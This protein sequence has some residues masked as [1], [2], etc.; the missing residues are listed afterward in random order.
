MG[1]ISWIGIYVYM[2]EDLLHYMDDTFTYDMDPILQYYSPYDT[3]YPSKQCRLLTLWD[4]IRLPHEQCKQILGQSID[5]ICLFVHP[6]EMTFTM[7]LV[8]KDALI[9]AIC[10]FIDPTMS[11]HCPLIEW[12]CL[13]G[14]M[15]WGLN[16]FPLLKPGLQSSY[17][18]IRG[19]SNAH[20]SIYL[21]K[22]VISDLYWVADTMETSTGLYYFE[23]TEW[24]PL[25]ADFV[26]FCD[27]SLSGLGF[28][29]PGMNVGFHADITDSTPTRTIFYNEALSVLS[30]LTW[31]L[32]SIP[33]I[34]KLLIYTDSMNT[35]EM[36]HSLSALPG[37]NDILLR[38]VGL[39]IPSSLSLRVLHI[40]GTENAVADAL[41]RGLFNVALAN[42]PG[43]VL[44]LFRPPPCVSGA[45][46]L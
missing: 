22:Q 6:I 37:Y 3:Y 19:K 5:I 46:I 38:A 16:T 4:D 12:Q 40:P 17:A 28:Y 20:A 44:R 24:S 41:S 18:K 7:L 30:A 31:C 25:E 43:L 14:W 1:L 2:I 8:S 26:I 45:D 29:C 36:F 11:C 23:A 33:S 34:Q 42:H 10:L 15:N 13:L 27:A 9:T 21:N 39:L 35:V 32:D